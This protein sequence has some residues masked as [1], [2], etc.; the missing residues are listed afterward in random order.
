MG[1]EVN[2]GAQIAAILPELLL[3]GYAFLLLVLSA[4]FRG[5]PRRLV[6]YLSLLCVGVTLALVLRA[7]AVLPPGGVR[8]FSGMFALD[9]FSLFFK[10]IFLTAAFLAILQSL[11]FLEI[12]GEQ[13]G[14]YYALILFAVVGM[15]FMASSRD[16]VMVYISLE[17]MSLTSYVLVAYLQRDPRSNEA[18]IKYMVLGAFSSGI[19]VYGISL[20]YGA[21]GTTDLS[22]IAF[23]A[24]SGTAGTILILGMLLMMVSLGFKVAAAPFHM[25]VPDAYQGAPTPITGFISTASKAAAFAIFVRIFAE[26]F[27][28]LAEHWMGLLSI[29]AVLSMTI[30]NIAAVLQENMKRMLAYSSIAHA[31]YALMG[32]IAIGRG[33]EVGAHGMTAVVIYM[34]VYTFMNVGAFG[35][36]VLLR[37]GRIAGDQ[38]SDFAGMARRAPVAAGAMLILWYLFGA[39]IRAGFTWLAVA[40]VLNSAI[41]LYYYLRVVVYM[42]M[43]PPADEDERYAASPFLVGALAISFL[44]TVAIGCYPQPFIELARAALLQ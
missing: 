33:G 14:E 13:S 24:R 29:V 3:I 41:S 35:F 1:P 10:V 44:F 2:W 30:G 25:W 22:E 15:M 16:L 38:V 28:P 5:D 40:A 7:W 6:G 12:E 42:Y 36:V 27:Q 18:G 23:I 43:K 19:F 20:V 17:T 32:L 34:L 26:A 4:I 9:G 11:R 8:A 31:G 21:T 39:A 37:R